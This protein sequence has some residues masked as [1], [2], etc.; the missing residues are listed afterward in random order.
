MSPDEEKQRVRDKINSLLSSNPIDLNEWKRL[1]RGKYGFVS[2][3]QRSRVWPKI[4]GVNRFNI[5]DYKRYVKVSGCSI[6]QFFA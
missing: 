3:T 5:P 2:N 1:S 6:C 4:L